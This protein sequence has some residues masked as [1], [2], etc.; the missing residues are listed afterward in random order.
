VNSSALSHLND[1]V[2]IGVVVV[3]PA[4]GDLDIL[5]GHADVLGV[6][7]EVF[8]GGH[9]NKLDGALVAKGLVGP[10]SH[11]AD[12]L[13]GSNAVVRDKDLCDDGVAAVGE[14]K[15]ADRTGSSS[16]DRVAT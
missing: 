15:V 6:R 14:D 3:V 12:L 4:T 2:D 8:G 13:D 10:F 16:L 7:L 11:G 5:V 9:D 1:K